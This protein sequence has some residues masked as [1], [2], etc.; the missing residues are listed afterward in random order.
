MNYHMVENGNIKYYI[1]KKTK[2]KFARCILMNEL[3]IQ[4]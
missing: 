4:L 2:I 3:T 1:H